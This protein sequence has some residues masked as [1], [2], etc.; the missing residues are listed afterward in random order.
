MLAVFRSNLFRVAEAALICCLYSECAHA[1][2]PIRALNEKGNSLTVGSVYL[3]SES[4]IDPVVNLL[5]QVPLNDVSAWREHVSVKSKET[6][7]LSSLV[8][9]TVACGYLYQ[10]YSPVYLE[11]M[12]T[13]S[14]QLCDPHDCLE[15]LNRPTTGLYQNRDAEIRIMQ[16]R[17]SIASAVRQAAG[18]QGCRL[19]LCTGLEKAKGCSF[20]FEEG[21]QDDVMKNYSSEVVA[22]T[23]LSPRSEK[24]ASVDD[25]KRRVS[26]VGEM[27]ITGHFREI[28]LVESS[29][30]PRIDYKF[31]SNIHVSIFKD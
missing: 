2:V 14:D 16:W 15:I 7:H 10:F 22:G 18:K 21:V 11:T 4:G 5:A 30:F 3:L 26:V 28:S 8:L 24:A 9:Q 29:S 25:A 12:S 27:V 19:V 6:R 20:V 17:S 13:E 31:N 23:K 1:Q